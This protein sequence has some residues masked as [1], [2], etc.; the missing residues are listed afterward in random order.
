[1]KKSLRVN[2]LFAELTVNKQ[3]QQNYTLVSDTRAS[4]IPTLSASMQSGTQ[5]LEEDINLGT[6]I[7]E[8]R[9]VNAAEM[10]QINTVIAPD[11]E[12][13]EFNPD[14]TELL[15]VD[16]RMNKKD[17]LVSTIIAFNQSSKEIYTPL[18]TIEQWNIDGPFPEAV[19]IQGQK[20]IPLHDMHTSL[21]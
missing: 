9:P 6:T 4:V 16:A 17:E 3:G 13:V 18:E 8:G 15:L 1:M 21:I 19:E 10:E 20:L 14:A 11:L 12:N 7:G 2:L 5:T